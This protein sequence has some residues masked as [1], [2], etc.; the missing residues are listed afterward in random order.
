M[1]APRAGRCRLCGR[2]AELP[3]PAPICAPCRSRVSDDELLVAADV[4][5]AV[6]VHRLPFEER[7]E[8]RDKYSAVWS[9]LQNERTAS[10]DR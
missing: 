7:R 4:L 9:S 6:P 2:P 10:Y 5:E 1:N 8:Y 3:K